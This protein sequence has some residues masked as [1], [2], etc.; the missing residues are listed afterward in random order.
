MIF[1]MRG[2]WPQPAAALEPLT[3]QA[4]ELGATQPLATRTLEITGPHRNVCVM[5]LA[6]SVSDSALG[7]K[8]TLCLRRQMNAVVWH[9]E[10]QGQVQSL[11]FPLW[12]L[13][14]E[15]DADPCA[16]GLQGSDD[17]DAARRMLACVLRRLPPYP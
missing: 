7:L 17:N 16:Q 11:D 2:V 1:I 13:D 5:G 8:G 9:G 12:L 6:Y 10:W 14:S 4:Q 15:D 3:P